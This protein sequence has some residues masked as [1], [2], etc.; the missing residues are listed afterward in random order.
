[1]RIRV[2]AGAGLTSAVNIEH[3]LDRSGAFVV[4]VLGEMVMNFLYV[5]GR[6]GAG[7]G[8]SHTYG[9]AVMGL[10]IAWALNYLYMIPGE[11]INK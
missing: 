10:M 3:S 7:F 9:K 11:E 2:P 6:N 5:A 8:A 4:I 1:M